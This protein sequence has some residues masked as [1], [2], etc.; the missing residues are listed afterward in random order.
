MKTGSSLDAVGE[1]RALVSPLDPAAGPGA[2][3]AGPYVTDADLAA[4]APPVAAILRRAQ[5]SQPEAQVRWSRRRAV[6]WGTPAVLGVLAA[7]AIA[8]T[9]LRSEAP[10][11]QKDGVRCFTVGHLTTDVHYYTD[12][13]PAVP[14][15]GTPVDIS[16]TVA[17]A[18]K[19]CAGLW[20]VGLLEPTGLNPQFDNVPDHPVPPLVACVLDDGLAAVL[21]GDEQTCHRL[22]LPRLIDRVGGR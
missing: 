18:I 4:T 7:G 15:A 12:T 11:T 2:V 9:A 3:G 5:E 22:N 16:A 1:I 14:M 10:A 13:A 19:Q 20:Q 17:A 6:R 8:A 21:P